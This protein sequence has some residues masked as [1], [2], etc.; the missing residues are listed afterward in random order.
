MATAASLLSNVRKLFG[1]PD[2]DFI[3]DAVGLDW[4]NQS[5]RRFCHEVLALDEYKDY[6]IVA[7]Q[8]KL[9]LPTDIII[10]KSVTWYQSRVVKLTYMPPALFM[11]VL[12]ANPSS[13]GTPENYSI[14]RSQIH[15]GPQVPQTRSA[16][17]L[18]SGA[19]QASATTF[20]ITASQIFRSKGFVKINSEVI[21][22][23]DYATSGLTGCVRGVHNTAA[24]SHASG[25]VVTQIDV[26]LFYSRIASA[27]ATTGETPEISAAYHDYIEKYTLYLAWLARGD[28]SKANAAFN[29]FKQVE[30]SAI[31]TVGRR[32][33]DGMLKIKEKVNRW[34]WW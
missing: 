4:L 20:S 31:K 29:E 7:K 2:S 32:S 3:T 33:L 12:E 28:L 5:Q 11:E 18:A 24:A 26:Q 30:D 16:T 27:M 22:Y 10:P 15:L 25:D 1:D 19:I 9:D 6:A 17:G 8:P 14:V 21:E 34:R 13:T 23:T